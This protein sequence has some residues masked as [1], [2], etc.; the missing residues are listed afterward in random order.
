[1]AGV[2]VDHTVGGVCDDIIRGGLNEHGGELS[3]LE[4]V[5]HIFAMDGTIKLDV[6][7]Q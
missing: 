3:P 6:L 2:A 7:H 1:M 5:R 4:A